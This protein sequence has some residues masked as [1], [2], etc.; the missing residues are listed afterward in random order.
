MIAL[1]DDSASAWWDRTSTAGVERREEIVAASLTSGL[2]RALR[3]H[4]EPDGGGWTWSR[5]RTANIGHL[6][7]IP[8][9]SANGIPVQSGPSTLSPLSGGGGFG[10]SWRMVVELGPERRAWGIYPGG[11]SGNPASSRYR[12]RIEKWSGGVLD[13][14]RVPASPDAL[15]GDHIVS[16]LTLTGV[17][18]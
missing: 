18:Q 4:G 10:A 3:E 7:R 11:Q 8:D 12:D 6:L 2:A 16:R 5:I 17:T 15:S 14:L 1:L 9:W 13:T